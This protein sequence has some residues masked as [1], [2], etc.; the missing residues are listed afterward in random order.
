[1]H[2]HTHAHTRPHTH[3]HTHTWVEILSYLLAEHHGNFLCCRLCFYLQALQHCNFSPII[4]IIIIM[5]WPFDFGCYL[6]CC[7]VILGLGLHQCWQPLWGWAPAGHICVV[8]E[9][10]E[11]RQKASDNS[12]DPETT[13]AQDAWKQSECVYQSAEMKTWVK[14]KWA[15]LPKHWSENMGENKVSI[16]TKVLKW[17]HDYLWPFWGHQLTRLFMY[18]DII[19]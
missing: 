12:R 11:G 7:F 5:I 18:M 14:T 8:Q 9:D 10:G 6:L 2:T 13:E 15:Y 19:R 16:F 1:M 17:K 3:T 4:M